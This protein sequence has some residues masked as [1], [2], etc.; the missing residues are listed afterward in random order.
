MAE[1]TRKTPEEKLK[2]LEQKIEQM[3]A[4]KKAI[5][6]K[7]KKAKR[8]ARSNRLIQIGVLSEKYFDCAEIEPEAYKKLIS[9]IVELPQVKALISK[10]ETGGISE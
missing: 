7:E 10:P 4:Q 1:R 6:E 9:K 3:Q 5:L 8:A 2:E